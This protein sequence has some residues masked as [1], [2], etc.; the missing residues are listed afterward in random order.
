MQEGDF[1]EVSVEQVSR[2][3]NRPPIRPSIADNLARIV[4][5]VRTEQ[6]GNDA[7][8]SFYS[9]CKNVMDLQPYK[10]DRVLN[11]LSTLDRLLKQSRDMP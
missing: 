10:N 1:M 11:L 2:W 7:R 5:D 6:R 4:V 8:L 3:I 9:Q